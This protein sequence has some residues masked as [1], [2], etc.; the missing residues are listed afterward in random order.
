MAQRN[1]SLKNPFHMTFTNKNLQL[2]TQALQVVG[3]T[4]TPQLSDWHTYAL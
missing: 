1:T 2:L 4:R 3:P